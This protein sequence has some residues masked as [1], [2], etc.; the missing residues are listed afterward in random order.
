MRLLIYDPFSCL[1]FTLSSGLIIV[2]ILKYF[3]NK[4]FLNAFKNF[5]SDNFFRVTFEKS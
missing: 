3:Q 4:K 5:D 2:F 1:F